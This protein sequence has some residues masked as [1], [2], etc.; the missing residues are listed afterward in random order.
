MYE[1]ESD[2]IENTIANMPPE[3]RAGIR[4]AA[5]VAYAEHAHLVYGTATPLRSTEIRR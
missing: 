5:A 3:M 2:I 1:G 4:G